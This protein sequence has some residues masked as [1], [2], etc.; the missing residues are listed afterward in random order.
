MTTL[1]QQKI[2]DAAKARQA[3]ADAPV[4][5]WRGLTDDFAQGASLG[6]SDEMTAALDRAIGSSGDFDSSMERQRRSREKYSAAN[7]LKSATARAL[8]AVAPVV[9]SYIGGGA[10]APFTAGTSMVLP[11]AATGRAIPLVM[12][13][14]YGVGGAGK[15]AAVNTIGRGAYEG[16]KASII[17]G[18]V[19]GYASANPGQREYGAAQ[20]SVVAPIFGGT[21][22]G[23]SVALPNAL[24]FGKEKL[25]DLNQYLAGPGNDPER[26][27]IELNPLKTG[28]RLTKL[29]RAKIFPGGAPVDEALDTGP[30]TITPRTPRPR[31]TPSPAPATTAEA[32]IMQAM[33]DGNITQ[34]QAIF[35]IARAQQL[36]VPLTIA[37]VGGQPV[38]R[39]AREIRTKTGPGSAMVDEALETRARGGLA[40]TINAI[41][42]GVGAKTTGN[43]A[44]VSDRFLEQA[45]TESRPY[46]DQL[47]GL[48]DISNA[49]VRAQ[50]Q[51]PAVQRII[52]AEEKANRDVGRSVSPLYN[53][54]GTLA[55]NPTFEELDTVKKIVGETITANRRFGSRPTDPIP[56]QTSTEVERAQSVVNNLLRGADASSGGTIYGLARQNFE[57]PMQKKN[58]FDAGI[59]QFRTKGDFETLRDIQTLPEAILPE[60]LK[61]LRRG[62]AEALRYRAQS[63]NDQ[64]SNPSRTAPIYGNENARLQ[65]DAA[66]PNANRR[67][68]M[69]ERF[70]MENQMSKTSNY[71][72]GGSN[73]ADKIAEAAPNIIGDMAAA[74]PGGPQAVTVAGATGTWNAMKSFFGKET[75]AEIAGILTNMNPRQSI[76]FL[77]RLKSLQAQGEVTSKAIKA[78]AAAATTSMNE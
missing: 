72:R 70:A 59:E 15:V 52:Q 57:V 74:A 1:A 8:G 9:M 11:A 53:D 26:G 40:R 22:G 10:A 76:A 2:L 54:D 3:A 39:L 14:L 68:R 61:Y 16:A 19:E 28:L 65:L 25:D 56:A 45:R 35:A 63:P 18:A 41:E 27:S 5:H 6:T 4:G 69:Q 50:M 58:A 38:Q 64:T 71:V 21:V 17:P 36:N 73:T 67:E 12:E 32:R 75:R 13:A 33:Y 47:P 48:P 42:R 62:Q 46:Y 24:R 77:E 37:D 31:R 51:T 7:P 43:P 55:R 29:L 66:V 23:T 44:A 34:D 78:T 20:G 30:P 60:N 49:D